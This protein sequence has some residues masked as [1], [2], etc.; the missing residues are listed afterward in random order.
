MTS[1]VKEPKT[2]TRV[3]TVIEDRKTKTIQSEKTHSNINNIVAKAHRTGQLPIL[4]RRQPIPSLPDAMSYQ[5]ALD[6]VVFAQQ[7]FER[8]PAAVR[9]EFGNNPQN[10]LQAVEQS[11]NN[12]DMKKALQKIGILNADPIDNTPPAQQ[13][14]AKAEPVATA[15]QGVGA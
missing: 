11:Q 14:E 6:K 8:L 7:S 10:M 4:M 13:G 3:Q 2:R 15:T 9:A 5:E 1:Q 12:P